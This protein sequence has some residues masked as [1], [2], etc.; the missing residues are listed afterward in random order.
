M[1]LAGLP[2]KVQANDGGSVSGTVKD[3]SGAV[4]PDA[5]V[6]ASNTETA[7][8]QTLTTND[9]GVYSF[10]NLPVGHYNLDVSVPGFRPYRRT[11]IKIDVNSSLL[12]DAVLELGE[13]QATISVE[14][15]PV[16]AE[17]AS[18]QRGEVITSEK[19]TSLP[20]NGR[21]YTDLLALQPG[22]MPVTT[23]TSSTVQGLGQTVFSPSGDLN[24]GTTS[25]N[26]QRESANGFMVN[27]ANAEE[28]GS[29]AAA[30]IPNLD[31]ISEFRILVNSFDAEYGKYSGGQINVITKSGTEE[32]HGD[33]FEFL[34]N[35]DLDATNF[36]SPTRDTF[37][38][39]QFGGTIGGPI[40]KNQVFFFADYQGTRLIKGVDS[41]Q[42]PVPSMQDRIGNL[43]DIASSF[44]TI[45]ANGNT[46]PSTVS[47][48]YL[49]SLLSRNLG[50]GPLGVWA[51]EA[52]YT[53]AC[54]IATCVF[55]GAVIPPSA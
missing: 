1:M 3:P 41:G 49:A 36:F 2:T 30:I 4:I 55:P 8:R 29:M 45:D 20:L 38:Q 39:N 46:V 44:V 50:L 43:S 28:D 54:T 12:V 37:I 13:S 18:T 48:P 27:G 32:F 53:P 16:Q 22:V 52:Y 40:R 34:R 17:T 25:I 15:S 42:I 11:N 33:A 14:E 47:G 35:T 51:G 5:V 31:S 26:G 9:S 6:T 24:P 21:S 23:M 7:A 19:V 10:Q